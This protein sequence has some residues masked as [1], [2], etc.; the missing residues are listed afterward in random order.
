MSLH[1]AASVEALGDTANSG[2]GAGDGAGSGGGGAEQGVRV[3]VDSR[4]FRSNVVVGGL[5]AW[6]NSTGQTMAHR[7]RWVMSR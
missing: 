1:G 7:F 4:R 6:E 3:D 5:A 2:G